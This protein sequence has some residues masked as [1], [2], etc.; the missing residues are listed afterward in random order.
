[1]AH[2]TGRWF[3]SGHLGPS[4]QQIA[5]PIAELW[6]MMDDKLMDGPE[7]SAGMRKLLEAKD[8][9]VRQRILDLETKEVNK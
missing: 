7:K 1:M 4:L 9:F 8:C 3:K 5:G 2:F 6:V